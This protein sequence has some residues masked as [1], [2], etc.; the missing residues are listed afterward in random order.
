MQRTLGHSDIKVS[1]IGMGCW[2]IGGPFLLDGRPDGWGDVDDQQS[3]RALQ[4]AI[5]L[6]ITFFD[7]ADAYGTGHSE[8]IIGRAI[9]GQ[10][11]KV[12]IATKFGY[13]YDREQRALIGTN[14]SPE[15]IRWACQQSLQRLGTD[16][17]DL[18]QLHVGG[19]SLEESR[20]VW[21]TLD[22]LQ[23]EGLIRSYGWS[24]W[25]AEAAR[26]FAA[27]TKGV[28]LQHPTNVLLDAPAMF[29]VCEEY[30][31]SSI[32]N[33]PLAMGLLSGKFSADSQLSKQ[34][35]RGSGHEWVAYFKDGKPRPEFL[36][37]LEAV[38]E[39]LTSKGRSLVQGALAW[40]WGR[41]SQSIPIPGFKNSKQL[42]ENADAL[43]FGP[44][45]PEQIAEIDR[46]LG[47]SLAESTAAS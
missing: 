4:E 16:Y 30:G 14:I 35:V 17:I 47:R 27:Q 38:R 12:V 24:T 2:A 25:D 40:H 21:E 42:I 37:Q 7:T 44:L 43:R 31:L 34:D 33:S 32:N 9:K 5:E 13:S 26:D 1:A 3:I 22:A 41:S 28:A 36:A 11:D 23:Q 18:Y 8:E 39:I 19:L 10:R 6:G 29:E 45:S 46:I 20:E 15:Y